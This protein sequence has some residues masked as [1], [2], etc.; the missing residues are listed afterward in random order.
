MYKRKYL[1]NDNYFNKIDTE[2]KAYFVGII[3][4]DGCIMESQ[5]Q[6]KQPRLLQ[7]KLSG[8]CDKYLVEKMRDEI[9]PDSPIHVEDDKNPKHQIKYKV[10]ISSSQICS[11]LL[12]CNITPRKS[13]TLKFPENIEDNLIPH[14]IRGYFDGDGGISIFRRKENWS[15]QYN[16]SFVGTKEFLS[17]INEILHLNADL[18]IQTILKY[19]SENNHRLVY[20]GNENIKK[21]Y[22]Y[23][24][25]NAAIFM[26]RKKTKLSGIFYA[27]RPNGNRKKINQLDKDTNEIIKTWECLSDASKK[28]KIS[29]STI[30]RVANKKPY[31]RSG[32]P[33]YTFLAAG[34]KWEYADTSPTI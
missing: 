30:S 6:N 32:K 34:F 5:T 22:N 23:I 25:E 29:I 1:V 16:I 14:V 13:L 7:F 18:P 33:Y 9:S 2:I 8:E 17:S 3:A 4:A 11:D 20:C 15:P 24:Y 19:D 31:I 28:L 12:K 10:V 21:I 26:E 27:P